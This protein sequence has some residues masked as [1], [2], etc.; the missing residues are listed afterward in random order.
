MFR[1]VNHI[2][3]IFENQ[4]K[5][6]ETKPKK[7]KEL[8]QEEQILEKGLLEEYNINKLYYL[9]QNNN[10]KE[11]ID[12]R[13]YTEEQ[14]EKE[15][16]KHK[17]FINTLILNNGT[18]TT[19]YFYNNDKIKFRK[20]SKTTST[21]SIIRELRNFLMSDYKDY[22]D[23]DF[24]NC[25]SSIMLFITKILNIKAP[26]IYLYYTEREKI[27]N[28][29]YE[30]KKEQ[31]KIFINTSFFNSNKETQTTPKNNFEKEILKEIKE[32]HNNLN[33]QYLENINKEFLK[34]L[35]LCREEAKKS[36]NIEKVK[37]LKNDKKIIY[38]LE[39]RILCNLYHYYEN[40]ALIILTKYLFKQY[41]KYPHSLIFDG[42]IFNEKDIKPSEINK[43]FECLSVNKEYY[44]F[45][46]FK[47]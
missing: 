17:H 30:G 43:Y 44:F 16:K 46:F 23:L 36:K 41:K 24:I 1:L 2:W 5:N 20:F 39:G 22:K 18:L 4:N 14:A 7:Q 11:I 19:N 27:I 13:N 12:K 8:T 45:K 15:L 28:K 29:Y 26:M 10:L 31:V 3:C 6:E 33:P 37:F 32:I 9:L 21:Q 25:I 38:N 35:L 47:N 40:K 42:L 34:V